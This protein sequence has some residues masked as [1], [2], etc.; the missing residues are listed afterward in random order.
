MKKKKAKTITLT[1]IIRF[2]IQKTDIK[3]TSHKHP[4]NLERYGGKRKT[5][6]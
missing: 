6:Q 5:K 4:Y 3:Y 2:M 1:D